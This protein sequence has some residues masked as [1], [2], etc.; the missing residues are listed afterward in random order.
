MKICIITISLLLSISGF[1]QLT[2]NT[3]KEASPTKGSQ[4]VIGIG[5]YESGIYNKVIEYLK[6]DTKIQVYAVCESHRIIGFKTINNI[7]K[8]YDI[9]RD[10]L[11]SY[12]I[13]LNIQRKDDS[14]FSNE[15]LDE[16]K[17]Q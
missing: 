6:N 2:S 14:I 5:N 12:F 9:V 3:T 10:L 13:D 8:S 16:I 11:L 1:S 15:C 17:K 7:Y 4:Y